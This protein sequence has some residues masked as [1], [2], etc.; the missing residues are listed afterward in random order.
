MTDILSLPRASFRLKI[1]SMLGL[2]TLADFLFYGHQ[3]GWTIGLFGIL[4][5]GICVLHNAHV[6]K[7]RLGQV[8][9]TL[10]L[11]QCLLQIE[12][13]SLLSFI[14]MSLGVMSLAILSQGDWKQDAVLWIRKVLS[15]IFRILRPLNKA[16]T[17]F[18]KFQRK[19]LPQGNVMLFFRGWFL[20][21]AFS[22]V[23]IALFSVANPVI[24]KW[25]SLDWIAFLES[26]FEIFSI[27]RVLFWFIMS[28]VVF[29]L[30]RPRLKRFYQKEK[31]TSEKYKPM[32]FSE[33]AF[34]KE[35]VKRS[36]II[37]NLLFAFQTIMDMN[38]LWA[39]G[40]LP[41]GITYAGYAQ[42]GAYPLVITALLACVFVLVAQNAGEQV[43]GST[44][45]RA[46]IYTWVMQN[47]LLV[48]SSIYRTGLYVEAY[49]LTYWRVAAFIWMGLVACGLCWIIARSILNKPNSWLIN[50]NAIT[51]LAVLYTTSLVNVGGMIA[52]Y[53][54]LHSREIS[55]SG[56]SLDLYYMT[57]I[58][59]SAIPAMVHYAQV[60]DQ[61]IDI[62]ST[63]LKGSD[64]PEGINAFYSDQQNPSILPEI[65][66]RLKNDMKD[67]RRWT[68]NEHRLL[69][70]L[71][72]S[73]E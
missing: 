21:G 58:G 71:V 44:S 34:T 20:P 39:G 33:W 60:T 51:L 55:G 3:V 66:D 69:K 56:A 54:V 15:A 48:I 10:T 24:K 1:I 12:K 63:A 62:T 64:A 68:Y 42:K 19:S 53:N 5:T 41:E 22:V 31:T 9:L 57:K 47:I 59:A 2:V 38:Y 17:S 67:W 18:R 26:F 36:L 52:H 49:A 40:Q 13:I 32:N 6:L 61:R 30:I 23:F 28:A 73:P 70:S 11:G 4:L 25:I 8:I 35:A 7:S 37:F 46:L 72:L 27:S 45:V 29:S 65:Q 14:L 50:A 43:S 16:G